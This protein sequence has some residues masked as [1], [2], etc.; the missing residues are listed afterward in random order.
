LNTANVFLTAWQIGCA[1]A[2]NPSALIGFRFLAG[3]GGSACLTIGGGIISDLFAV[4]QRGMANAMFSIGP[5]FGPV[6][7]PIIGGFIAQRAGWRWVYWV[8]LAA[9]GTLT[10][11]N[12]ALNSETNP[13]VLVRRRTEKLRKELNRTDL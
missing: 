12:I 7:G 10:L 3:V 11:G 13:V 1:L 6:I 4:E 5:L 2:P 9:C 8:L